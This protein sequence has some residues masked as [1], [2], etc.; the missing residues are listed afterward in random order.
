MNKTIFI[1]E[2]QFKRIV[3]KIYEEETLTVDADVK[4]GDTSAALSDA[5]RALRSKGL[6][7]DTKIAVTAK[8]VTNES[9][10]TKKQ[11]KE[12]K[13]RMM[14]DNSRRIT[15]RQSRTH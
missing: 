10:Y 6:P 8:E 3:N 11:L 14:L 5:K 15:K 7:D 4:N 13:R 9:V 1:T 2:S 12:A